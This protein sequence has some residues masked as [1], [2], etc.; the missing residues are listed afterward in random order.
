MAD[1]WA[2]D[3]GCDPHATP[4]TCHSTRAFGTIALVAVTCGE[5]GAQALQMLASDLRAVDEACSRFRADSELRQVERSSRGRPVPVSP[6]LFELLEVAMTVAVQTAG[7]VDPTVGSALVELGYDR[8]FDELIADP[9]GHGRGMGGG[10][11]PRPAPGWWRIRL[12]GADGSVAIPAGILV[13]LGSTAKAFA[14]DRSAQRIAAA[15]G[16]GVLVN[17][18][19]DVAV[20]G[21]GPEDGWHV[22]IAEDCTAP[23]TESDQVVSLRRGGLATSGTT[24]RAWVRH[25]RRNHHIVDP[26]TGASASPVWSW[27][28]TA[29]SS[30]VEANAWS[31]AAVVWGADA[32]GNLTGLGVPARLVDAQGA[33]VTTGHWPALAVR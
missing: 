24:A 29:A 10:D 1:P 7:T 32:V 22:G 26:W 21:A 9:D 14:A 5:R 12:D 2:I 3:S 31:T 13:D 6:L 30:C 15:L 19:G 11:E 4:V 17:L 18:G 27:V 16:G 8:D 20:A 33:S 25:G 23:V 28:S